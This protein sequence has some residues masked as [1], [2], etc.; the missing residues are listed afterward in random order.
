MASGGLYS[1]I[2]Q[3]EMTN[4]LFLQYAFVTSSRKS[5]NAMHAYRNDT[6]VY[7]YKIKSVFLTS[8]KCS[9]YTKLVA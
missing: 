5:K 7:F 3:S 4:P 6:Q 1:I 8:I 9:Y 2:Y